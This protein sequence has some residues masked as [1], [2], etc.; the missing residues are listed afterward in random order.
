MVGLENVGAGEDDTIYNSVFADNGIA[1]E[2][3]V[4]DLA[5]DYEEQSQEAQKLYGNV[6][7]R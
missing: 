3:R 4:D 7:I 6:M 5:N 2:V 1:V